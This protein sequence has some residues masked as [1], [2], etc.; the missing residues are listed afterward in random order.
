MS[1]TRF[2]IQTD[3]S[4]RQFIDMT[5]TWSE[6]LPAWQ[7]MV[8]EVTTLDKPNPRL[9]KN[10]RLVM[11]NFWQQMEKMALAADRWNAYV[12][13]L[14]DEADTDEATRINEGLTPAKDSD[15]E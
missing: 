3:P 5:P 13:E 11:E 12:A 14:N 2:K 10:P 1:D 7:M 4:G 9:G 8:G 15:H 6:I